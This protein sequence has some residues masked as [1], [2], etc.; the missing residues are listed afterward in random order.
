VRRVTSVRVPARFT[1]HDVVPTVAVAEFR[2]GWGPCQRNVTSLRV[3]YRSA[4]VL[5]IQRHDDGTTVEFA[6]PIAQ[7]TGRVEVRHG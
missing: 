6:Y 5:I 1:L 3:E 7:L 4:F 2:L